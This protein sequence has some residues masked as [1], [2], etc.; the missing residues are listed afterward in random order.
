[1][2]SKTKYFG[3][4]YCGS[5]IDPSTSEPDNIKIM[6]KPFVISPYNRLRYK[7]E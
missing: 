5:H 3:I 7:F 6:Y 4:T 2:W 1:M